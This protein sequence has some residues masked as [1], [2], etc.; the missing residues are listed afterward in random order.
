MTEN[1]NYRTTHIITTHTD[2]EYEMIQG[3]WHLQGAQ[4]H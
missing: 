1:N 3:E 4:A 2:E